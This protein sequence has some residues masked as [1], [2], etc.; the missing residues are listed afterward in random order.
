MHKPPAVAYL[1]EIDRLVIFG[2][3]AEA[4]L[5]N[6]DIQFRFRKNTIHPWWS[7]TKSI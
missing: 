6:T 2:Y 5:G 4:C 1:R 3:E 7:R